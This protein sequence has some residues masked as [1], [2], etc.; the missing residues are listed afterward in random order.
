MGYR[1]VTNWHR[2]PVI[3]AWELTASERAE[4]D[5][6]DWPAIEDGRDS[7]SFVRYRGELHDL[8]DVM[9]AEGA[10]LAA[11]WHGFNSD[12]FFSGTAYRYVTDDYGDPAVIVA[13]VYAEEGE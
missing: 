10:I 11:G 4:F 7:A 8:G 3:E 12:S 13:R 5:Y 1:Y 2:R 6:L 9:C